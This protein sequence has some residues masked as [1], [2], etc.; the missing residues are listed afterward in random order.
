MQTI[1]RSFASMRCAHLAIDDFVSLAK[2]RAAF[3]VA[4]HDVMHKQVA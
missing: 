1:G 3:A 4:E 2:Q